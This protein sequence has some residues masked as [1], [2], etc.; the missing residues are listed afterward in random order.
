[1]VYR[2]DRAPTTGPNNKRP[3][4]PAARSSTTGEWRTCMEDVT[5]RTTPAPFST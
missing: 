3:Y 5:W 2:Q 1:M 4:T